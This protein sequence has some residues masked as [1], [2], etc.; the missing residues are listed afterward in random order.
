MGPPNPVPVAHGR[1]NYLGPS[2]LA[3]R[4]PDRRRFGKAHFFH[5]GMRQIII[6]TKRALAEGT[7]GAGV[8]DLIPNRMLEPCGHRRAFGLQNPVFVDFGD[9]KVFAPMLGIV[10]EVGATAVADGRKRQEVLRALRS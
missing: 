6:V 2:I 10:E 5:L 7:H 3:L 1:D 4:V 9:P 8:G